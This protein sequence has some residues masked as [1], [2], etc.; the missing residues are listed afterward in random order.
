MSLKEMSSTDIGGLD[1]QVAQL[2]MC[3]PL[4]EAEVKFLCEKVIFNHNSG[5]RDISERK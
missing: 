1:V 3:K 5:K 2:M 4:K